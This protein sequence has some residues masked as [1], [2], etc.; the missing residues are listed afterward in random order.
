MSLSLETR[1]EYLRYESVCVC[2]C[3]SLSVSVS[4]CSVQIHYV[5]PIGCH[6]L[7]AFFWRKLAT[8]DRFV[9]AN[10]LYRSL[11]REMTCNHVSL[12]AK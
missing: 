10:R 6:T 1:G 11:V 9:C 8:N 3:M 5:G 2:L 7:Q 12:G 4:E